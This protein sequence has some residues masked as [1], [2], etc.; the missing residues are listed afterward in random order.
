MLPHKTEN[1]ANK[2]RRDKA[3]GKAKAPNSRWVAVGAQQPLRHGEAASS[4]P[5][6]ET[7]AGT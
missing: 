1:L 2:L 6:T 5:Q 4:G 7:S 3:G